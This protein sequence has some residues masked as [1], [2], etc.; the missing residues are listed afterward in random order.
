[1][2]RGRLRVVLGVAPGAGKTL[3]LLDEA[4]RLRSIGVDAVVAFAQTRGREALEARLAGLEIVL[5]RRAEHRGLAVFDLDLDAVLARRPALA[6]VDDVA[7]TNIPGSRHRKRHEDVTALLDAGVDVL[8]A[9]DVAHLDSLADVVERVTGSGVRETVPDGFLRQADDVICLDVGADELLARDPVGARALGASSLAIL[10]ELALREVAEFLDR[11]QGPRALA[12]PDRRSRGRVMVC[13]SSHPPSAAALLWRGSRLA[14]RLNTHWFV[15]YVQTPREA[16][17]RID[18]ADERQLQANVALARE[19]GAE[20]VHL[21]AVDPVDALLDFARS[22][23]VGLMVLGRSRQPWWRQLT[24]RSIPLRLAREAAG[25]D[26]HVVDFDP[27][28]AR[29]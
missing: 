8:C 12:E 21:E 1:M 10:R 22:H 14:G 16:P 2:Q 20:V 9:L 6:V 18:A 11:R 19:L 3:R 25:L 7:H 28:E 23:N 5:R 29:T 13:L 15:V 17:T 27:Q 4:H 26:L 24:G